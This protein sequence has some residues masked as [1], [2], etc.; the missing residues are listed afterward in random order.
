MHADRMVSSLAESTVLK[1]SQKSDSL[2][3]GKDERSRTDLLS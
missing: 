2:I 1:C 3:M